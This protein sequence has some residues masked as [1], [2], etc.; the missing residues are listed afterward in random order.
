MVYLDFLGSLYNIQFMKN[1]TQPQKLLKHVRDARRR[2][3]SRSELIALGKG[4]SHPDRAMNSLVK[5]G[6]AEKL[7]RGVWL[8]PSGVRPKFDV[9]RFWSNPDLNDPLTISALVVR[10]PTMRDMARLVLAYGAAPAEQALAELE[11]DGEITP[12]AALRSRRMI[13]NAK[14]GLAHAAG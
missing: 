13:D 5:A 6:H 7:G 10:N 12:S 8:V 2:V 4:M 9:P 3:V 1:G 11:G 14:L